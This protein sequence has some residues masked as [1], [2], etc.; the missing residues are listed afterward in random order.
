MR[1]LLERSSCRDFLENKIPSEILRTVLEAGVHAP[2]AGN[3]Q[4]Y[5][6]IKIEK[7]ETRHKLAK[8]PH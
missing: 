8:K 6:I 5:S 1:L 7:K 3:L 4:P 2:T